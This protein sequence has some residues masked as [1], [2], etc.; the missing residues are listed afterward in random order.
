MYNKIDDDGTIQRINTSSV[1]DSYEMYSKGEYAGFMYRTITPFG[2]TS[3]SI[4]NAWG[5]IVEGKQ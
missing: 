1:I 3:Y 2:I 4:T 5:D